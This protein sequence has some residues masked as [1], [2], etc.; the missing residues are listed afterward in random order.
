MSD[1]AN[2]DSNL[3]IITPDGRYVLFESSANNLVPTNNSRPIPSSAPHNRLNAYLRDRVGGSATLVSVNTNG[4][5]ANGD[6]TIS[7]VSTNGQF[8]LFESDATDLVPNDPNNVGDIF[9]RDVV[10]GTTTLVTVNTNGA[11]G[12]GKSWSSV[13][14]PDGRY[15]A[16]T[17]AATDFVPN[18]TNGIPNVFVRDMVGGVTVLVSMGAAPS[19]FLPKISDTPVITPDGRYVAFYSTATNLVPGITHQGEIYLRDMLMGTTTWASTN[20]Q[21]LY[22]AQ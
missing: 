10:N 5:G 22:Y 21:K 14:T 18:V 7:A 19:S 6:A 2:G 11:V 16:F 20:A 4:D 8:V 17:S 13:M 9:V 12:N 1:S 15:V 3:P